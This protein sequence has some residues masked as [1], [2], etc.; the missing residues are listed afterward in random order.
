[1]SEKQKTDRGR[2]DEDDVREGVVAADDTGLVANEM[3]I[4][5]VEIEEGEE[6]EENPPG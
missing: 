5:E 4:V 1:M 3:H 2:R 6:A